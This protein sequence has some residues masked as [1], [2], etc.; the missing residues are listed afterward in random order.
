MRRMEELLWHL[1]RL[2]VGALSRL[3]RSAWLAPSLLGCAGGEPD[4]TDSTRARFCGAL[5]ARLA[6]CAPGAALSSC[7]PSCELDPDFEQLN[8]QLWNAQAECI[9]RQTCEAL[10]MDLGQKGCFEQARATLIASDTCIA[11]CVADATASFECGAGHSVEGC[12]EGPFCT[13]RDE[14]LA[15]GIDCNQRVDCDERAACLRGVFG[16]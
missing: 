8:E 4:S 3:W 5:C 6:A 9:S 13:L 14:V 12:V 7:S 1:L 11:F 10:A 16:P 15:A 2:A